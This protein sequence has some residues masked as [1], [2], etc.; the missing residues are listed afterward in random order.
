MLYNFLPRHV[1]TLDNDGQWHSFSGRCFR[2][3]KVRSTEQHDGTIVIEADYQ[4]AVSWT[5]AE[6]VLYGNVEDFSV[7]Y[8]EMHGTKIYTWTANKGKIYFFDL[9]TSLENAI[10]TIIETVAFLRGHDHALGFVEHFMNITFDKRSNPGEVEISEEDIHPGDAIMVTCIDGQS[11]SIMWSGGSLASHTAMFLREPE[12]QKL[13]VVE[14]WYTGVRKLTFE[15]YLKNDTAPYKNAVHVPLKEELRDS[16]D[17][18]AAWKKFITEF[19]GNDYGFNNFLFTVVDTLKDNYPCHPMDDYQTC[20][21]WELIQVLLGLVERVRPDIANLLFLEAL[22]HRMN[23]TALNVSDLLKMA[24]AKLKGGSAVLPTIPEKDNWTYHIH[25]NGQA[26]MGPSRVCSALLC[27]L[28]RAGGALG[29]HE[30]SCS[31]FTPFDIY[32]MDIF[33]TPTHQLKGDYVI[34]LTKP[35]PLRLGQKSVTNNM[36]QRCGSIITADSYYAREPHC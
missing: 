21:S 3:I 22:N 4:D 8:E 16:F 2:S 35:E 6:Y 27:E 18:D 1:A 19:E 12:T 34:N 26:V 20:L 28:L 31:E 32:S 29:D 33:T 14:S 9:R 25:R 17:N 10:D 24:D 13:Y 5:C 11:T 23:T 36:A 15:E 30:L 7:R